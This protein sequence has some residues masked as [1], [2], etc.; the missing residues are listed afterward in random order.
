MNVNA[1]DLKAL[2]GIGGAN[3]LCTRDGYSF[4][5]FQGDVFR[6]ISHRFLSIPGAGM[7]R[8]SSTGEEGRGAANLLGSRKTGLGPSHCPEG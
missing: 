6:V 1:G 2:I 3:R 8:E 7:E 4:T 5:A